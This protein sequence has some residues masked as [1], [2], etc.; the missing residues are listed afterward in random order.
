MAGCSGPPARPHHGDATPSGIAGPVRSATID[1][2]GVRLR[3][4]SIGGGPGAKVVLLVHGGPGL[5]LESLDSLSPLAGPGLELVGYDQRGA[6][7]SSRPTDGDFGLDA[8]LADLDTVRRWTGAPQVD[9]VGASFGGLLAAAYTARLPDHVRRLVLLDPAPLDFGEFLAGQQRF[10]NHQLQL[11]QAGLIADPLP[12]ARGDSCV[13]M[14]L[15][16][17]PA[18]LGDPREKPP[19]G[20]I[21]TCTASTSHATYAA[22]RDRGRLDDLAA[23]LVHFDRPALVL[24]G[25]NDPF[26]PQ[27]A[28]RAQQ[29]L[30]HARLTR[31][32]IP[33]TGHLPYAE[34]PDLVLP[35]LAAFLS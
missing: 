10:G 24:D 30:V 18:Y 11:Q 32:R 4:R 5:D 34:R 35:V 13:P 31:I 23:G 28:T 3:V 17:L 15:A 33:G 8:Q 12:A 29:L 9:L 2:S 26:G 25:E 6:G 1:G 27:W 16:L 7:G 19:P 20:A 14:L 22:L 21:T